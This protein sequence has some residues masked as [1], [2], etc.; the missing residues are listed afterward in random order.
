M[1]ASATAGCAD[2]DAVAAPTRARTAETAPAK[3][4]AV[5]FCNAVRTR[6]RTRAPGDA[7]AFTPSLAQGA[8]KSW[9]GVA[10]AFALLLIHHHR[11]ASRAPQRIG[12]RRRGCLSEASSSP[13][14]FAR[15][16]GNRCSAAAS[17]RVPAVLSFGYFSLHK[18]RK[19]T[20]LSRS[21]G[22]S[23]CVCSCSSFQNKVQQQDHPR[24]AL[25]VHSTG[26]IFRRDTPVSSKNDAHPCASPRS[27]SCLP[28][29]SLRKGPGTS[30]ARAR[31]ITP[32]P[33]PPLRF[34]QGRGLEQQQQQQQQR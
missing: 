20:R 3:A 34:A 24:C 11:K 8:G 21:R 12:G 28:A 22:E 4:G 2:A 17:A 29:P 18:Q 26:R 10:S 13:P 7:A 25:Q 14:R 30:K 23:S 5:L 32:L 6:I 19:V 9:G 16:T 15:S 33:N 31:T 1:T 27:E